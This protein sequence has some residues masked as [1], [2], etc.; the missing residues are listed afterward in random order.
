MNNITIGSDPEFVIMCGDK[1]ENALEI[2]TRVFKEEI[3]CFESELIEPDESDIEIFYLQN[4]AQHLNEALNNTPINYLINSYKPIAAAQFIVLFK[5][6]KYDIAD[7]LNN[8]IEEPQ[9]L[10][11]SKRISSDILEEH[12]DD[13]IISDKEMQNNI[14]VYHIKTLDMYK[15]YKMFTIEQQIIF[16]DY[17]VNAILE[18]S[19]QHSKVG[20]PLLSGLPN[21]ISECIIDGITDNWEYEFEGADVERLFCSLE[22]G[23]DGQS[24]LGEM[25]PKFGNDPIEHFNEILKLMKKLSEALASEIVCYEEDLTVKAGTIQGNY[26]LG[27]HIHIGYEQRER[28]WMHISTL[29][30]YVLSKILSFFVGIPLTFI[31]KQDEALRRH[32]NYGKFGAY[33]H[34]D[35]GFEF[36]MPSSWL[37]SPEITIGAL[38]LAYVVAD[39]F[40]PIV[41][42]KKDIKEVLSDFYPSLEIIYPQVKDQYILNE[43]PQV[44]TNIPFIHNLIKTMKLYPEYAEYIDYIF[45]MIENDETWNS[46]G[47]ILAEWSKL[48]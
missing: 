27:G 8:R 18:I 30:N 2:F 29:T 31:E 13:I 32:A 10:E 6:F 39:E 38:S 46:D 4:P 17:L 23:C 19:S 33:E 16:D 43:Y 34:K 40:I 47:D 37:V 20:F 21:K 3:D 28:S 14:M 48:F 11:V 1:V 12:I 41:K 45:N 9:L 36:R 44:K 15:L 22:L 7:I 25:R 26:Q 24:A 42:N 35:Y 5:R